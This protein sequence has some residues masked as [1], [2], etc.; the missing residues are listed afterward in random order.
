M[1]PNCP[2]PTLMGNRAL[3][4][5]GKNMTE[6]EKQKR[7]QGWKE[8]LKRI[9]ES[10]KM[11]NAVEVIA[12]GKKISPDDEEDEGLLLDDD[13]IAE[14]DDFTIAMK[15]FGNDEAS[16]KRRFRRYFKGKSP[17]ERRDI[18]LKELEESKAY[19]HEKENWLEKLDKTALLEEIK[20]IMPRKNG[21]KGG[22]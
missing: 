19:F 20:E 3:I 1:G 22:K 2:L 8:L 11:F 4:K 18:M 5:K 7:I 14:N 9:R 10:E 12:K 21:K 16:E 17:E 6:A 15:L 13:F